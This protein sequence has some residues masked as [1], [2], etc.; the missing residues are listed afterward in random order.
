M[1]NEQTDGYQTAVIAPVLI[2]DMLLNEGYQPVPASVWNEIIDRPIAERACMKCG[3]L[4]EW[5]PRTL[6]PNGECV[7]NRG[8]SYCPKC[9]DEIEF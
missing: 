8:F 7:S 2:S 6:W 9:F 5:R 3:C 1:E 4:R